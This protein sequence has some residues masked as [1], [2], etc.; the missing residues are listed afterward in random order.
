MAKAGDQ[1]TLEFALGVHVDG[2]ADGPVGH[3]FVEIVGS[4]D[5]QFERYLLPRPEQFW[6]MPNR[7]KHLRAAWESVA[8]AGGQR[9]VLHLVFENAL[10][11]SASV[12]SDGLPRVLLC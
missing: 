7:L 11:M 2:V 5:L 10:Y 8:A 6:R 3:R 12:T 1:I 4:E 9:R